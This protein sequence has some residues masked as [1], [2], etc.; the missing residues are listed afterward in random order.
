[1]DSY[2]L[3]W[4]HTYVWIESYIN[5]YESYLSMNLKTKIGKKSN[6]FSDI[7]YE[8]I[9]TFC[10]NQFIHFVWII[11]NMYESYLI[12]MNHTYVW[13][14]SYI[15][16]MIH[17]YVWPESYIF[18]MPTL[19]FF[20]PRFIHMYDSYIICMIHTYLCMNYL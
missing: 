3:C 1:M 16:C 4:N 6:F 7:L 13:I 5:M 9:H 15:F 2:I 17:T 11:L 19:F 12:C 18:C 8:S 10:M 20:K 14:E